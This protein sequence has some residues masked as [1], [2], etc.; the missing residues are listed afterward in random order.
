MRSSDEEDQSPE[1]GASS[2]QAPVTPI[3]KQDDSGEEVE[4]DEVD[5]R[6]MRGLRRIQRSSRLAKSCEIHADR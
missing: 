1:L 5:V 3:R 6:R 4:R 2:S